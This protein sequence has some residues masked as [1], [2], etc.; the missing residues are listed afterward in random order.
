[1]FDMRQQSLQRLKIKDETFHSLLT[2]LKHPHL[3]HR[4][5][6]RPDTNP[7]HPLVPLLQY[8]M[9]T[10]L[11][12]DFRPRYDEFLVGGELCQRLDVFTQTVRSDV[13]CPLELARPVDC[14][15]VPVLDELLLVHLPMMGQ[16]ENRVG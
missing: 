9:T 15:L 13:T 11:V 5:E 3:N 1:M 4:I 7:Q 10:Q 12:V 16:F 2:A 14:W 6:I 8:H